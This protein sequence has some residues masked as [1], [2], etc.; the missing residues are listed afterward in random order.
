MTLLTLCR[1]EP[2]RPGPQRRLAARQ[3]HG[4]DHV[5]EGDIPFEPH[6]SRVLCRCDLYPLD[7]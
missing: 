6:K 2:K 7:R 5:E 1:A 4:A 3:G